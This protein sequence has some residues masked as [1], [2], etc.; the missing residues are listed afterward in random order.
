MAVVTAPEDTLAR[1]QAQEADVRGRQQ[2]PGLCRPEQF[3]G[4]SGMQIFEA[5]LQGE[6]PPAP[7]AATLGFTLVE[8]A[9]GRAEFQGRPLFAHYN[10]LGTVHGGWIATLL[11][12][13]V[14]CAVHSTL[15]PGK[16]YTTLEL[17]VNYVRAL[18]DKVPLVRAIGE[19][20]Y[21]G[22]KIGT[23]QG[24]LVGPDGTLFAH[25]T[26]TCIVLDARG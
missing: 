22:G 16:T 7:I 1:W 15:A 19:V 21:S 6:L 17:K 14:A 11:D 5:I 25:A 2:A 10:P 8:V 9:P 24:R 26:T 3:A 13:A 20:I 23:A 12:S 4:K 18:T